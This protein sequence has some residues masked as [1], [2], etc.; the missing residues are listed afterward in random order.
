MAMPTAR[1][2]CYTPRYL[3]NG[4]I[5]MASKNL[6][7]RLISKVAVGCVCEFSI[8]SNCNKNLR[9]R[10]VCDDPYRKYSNAKDE[11]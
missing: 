5:S 4:L 10:L 8:F 7:L 3:L 9:L 6:R 1:A 2:L 11:V